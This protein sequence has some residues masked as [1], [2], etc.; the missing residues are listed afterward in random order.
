V[1][2]KLAAHPGKALQT[3]G[4]ARVQKVSAIVLIMRQLCS[5]CSQSVT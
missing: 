3:D 5:V 1:S 4:D 2:S